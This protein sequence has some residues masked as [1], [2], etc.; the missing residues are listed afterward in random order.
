MQ[1]FSFS[2]HRNRL[3]LPLALWCVEAG[4]PSPAEGQIDEPLDLNEL[5]IEHPNATYFV[6]VKGD[7]MRDAG[8]HHGDL[9]IVDRARSPRSGDIVIA[10]LNGAFTVKRWR[11][12]SN[13][14]ISSVGP[15]AAHEL[16]GGELIAAHPQYPS[17]RVTH[18]DEFMIW[19]V[20][21]Y[22]IH[23]T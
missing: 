8:I 18:E 10:A 3:L 13:T 14:S 6:R 1:F 12:Y 19:G 17:M 22:T 11:P 15:M 7:S 23:R 20:V 4:F 21:R 9:L 5:L 16:C 2:Q